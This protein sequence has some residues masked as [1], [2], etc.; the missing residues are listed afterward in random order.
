MGWVLGV[1]LNLVTGSLGQGFYR[2]GRIFLVLL[3][4]YGLLLEIRNRLLWSLVPLMVIGCSILMGL[5]V[6]WYSM[7]VAAF[8][9]GREAAGD[10]L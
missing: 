6:P 4:L 1:G 3:A 9:G 5:F 8:C 10:L 7:A 2:Q